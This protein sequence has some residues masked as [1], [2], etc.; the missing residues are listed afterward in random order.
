MELWVWRSGGVGLEE[1]RCGLGGVEEWRCA[2]GRCGG[3][4]EVILSK[5]SKRLQA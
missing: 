1:L 4:G 5:W 2:G 3:R